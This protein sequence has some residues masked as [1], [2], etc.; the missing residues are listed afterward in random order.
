MGWYALRALLSLLPLPSLLIPPPITFHASLLQDLHSRVQSGGGLPPVTPEMLQQLAQLQAAGAAGGGPGGGMTLG[1]QPGAL[2]PGGLH[3]AAEPG[4]WL[5]CLSLWECGEGR[6]CTLCGARSGDNCW[7][8]RPHHRQLARAGP[9]E[10]RAASRAV[11][12]CTALRAALQ[13]TARRGRSRCPH[14]PWRTHRCWRGR[15]S[16]PGW[17]CTAG[18]RY[19]TWYCVWYCSLL[20]RTLPATAPTAAAAAHA[21]ATAPAAGQQPTLR[22]G[23][24]RRA[25]SRR[26]PSPPLLY[27]GPGCA[28][29]A[30]RTQPAATSSFRRS[31]SPLPPLPSGRACSPS[32]CRSS[33]CRCCSSA[34]RSASSCGVSRACGGFWKGRRCSSV[35]RAT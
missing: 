13:A 6:T 3:A 10:G 8:L 5:P 17:I 19:C 33:W 30:G 21:A 22:G 28:L 23:A 25:P 15:S 12:R 2:P 9:P 18:A 20:T 24:P 34:G 26:P 27:C 1:W 29:L 16:S 14:R 7:Q 32:G 11:L 4:K 31:S 35:P